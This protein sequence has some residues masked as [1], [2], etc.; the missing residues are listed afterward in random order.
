[1]VID[2]DRCAACQACTFACRAENN[3]PIAGPEE[4]EKGRAIFWHEMLV[5][6]GGEY[7]E[8]K[9]RFVPRPCMHCDTAPCVKVCPVHATFKNEEGIISQ[10]PNRCIGCRI[11]MVTCPYSA[12]SFNWFKPKWPENLRRHLNPDVAVRPKGV[13]EKCLFCAHRIRKVKEKAKKEGRKIRDEEVV[14][15]TACCQVCPTKARVFGDLDD[16]DSTVS[17]LRKSKRAFRLLEDLG[18]DPKVTYLAEGGGP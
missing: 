18:T 11:C 9:V 15:L 8:P 7:P 3:V 4:T 2:L 17:K 16:P 5:Y 13:V 10:I 14:R 12:R 6:R 1:M